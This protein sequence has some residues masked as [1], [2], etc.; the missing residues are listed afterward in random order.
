[1]KCI[2]LSII[3][4]FLVEKE[5][6]K[7]E[8]YHYQLCVKWYYC[9]AVNNNFNDMVSNSVMKFMAMTGCLLL[10]TIFDN[11]ILLFKKY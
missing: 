7:T 11:V 3:T 8:Q 5:K 6:Q 10:D 4:F 2:V 9:S 1:M